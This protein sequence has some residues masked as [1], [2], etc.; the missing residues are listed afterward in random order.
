LLSLPGVGRYTAGAV[1]SLAFGKRVPIVDANVA[2]VICRLDRITADPRTP[3]IQR[4][5][6]DRAAEILPRKRVG[7]FNS[8]LMELGGTVCR[9]KHPNC[10]R[11]PLKEFCRARAQGVQD[12]IPPAKKKAE[13]PRVLR[14]VYCIHSDGRWLI[15]QRPV[16]GRWGAMWQFV[17]MAADDSLSRAVGLPVGNP[18]LIGAVD[19]QLT[20]RQYHFDVFLCESAHISKGEASVV[21]PRRWVTL[22]ELVE[23][24]KPRPHVK[25]ATMIAESIESRETVVS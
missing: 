6:W 8:A 7:D 3:K 12:E 13:R 14:N 10:R 17:T 21:L 2:R 19:H 4:R 24:P 25:I 16:K 1:G 11:C 15:E 20:H 9:P 23:Y 18:K 5:L 22:Q